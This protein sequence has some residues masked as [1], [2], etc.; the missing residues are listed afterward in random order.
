[1]IAS[2]TQTILY[3][4]M[5]KDGF[6]AGKGGDLSFLDS[7]QIAG[8][9]YGYHAFLASVGAI[10]VGRKTYETVLNMGYPYHPDKPVYVL[11]RTPQT[12]HHENLHFHSGDVNTLIKTLRASGSGNI[13]CDGGAET[14][15]HLL[16]AN[17]IDR[18]ILSVVP[19][20]LKEGVELFHQG[21]VP[22]PFTRIESTH[23]KS[24]LIQHVF[25]HGVQHSQQ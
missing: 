22:Q 25:E 14:A 12:S 10:V 19:T 18:I 15:K 6:I 1:M 21:Q 13:Y 23:F 4:A 17:C 7:V 3:I 9:D 16:A 24:G 11:T 8:E 20:L 5:S 2:T